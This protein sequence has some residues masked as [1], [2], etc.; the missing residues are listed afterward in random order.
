[1]YLYVFESVRFFFGG[2][3]FVSS[4]AKLYSFRIIYFMDLLWF[5]MRFRTLRGMDK[6]CFFKKSLLKKNFSQSKSRL[7]AS[8]CIKIYFFLFSKEGADDKAPRE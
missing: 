1:M 7:Y 3:G 4:N 8:A 5:V 2:R 6:A